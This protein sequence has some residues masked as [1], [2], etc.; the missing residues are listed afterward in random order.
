MHSGLYT[1]WIIVYCNNSCRL[2]FR[3]IAYNC[4]TIDTHNIFLFSSLSSIFHL[5]NGQYAHL[6]LL[7][8]TLKS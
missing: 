7:L 8:C 4:C 6:M 1:L 3:Q 2:V 5:K